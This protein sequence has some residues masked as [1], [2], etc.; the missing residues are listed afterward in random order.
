[1][2]LLGVLRGLSVN[3]ALKEMKFT[4]LIAP[5]LEELSPPTPEELRILREG[6]D[7]ER[8]LIGKAATD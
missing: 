2:I 4:P 8:E 5:Q 6:I 7:P 3:D 1:M